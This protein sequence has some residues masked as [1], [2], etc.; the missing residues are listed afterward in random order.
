MAAIQPS[1]TSAGFAVARTSYG[2][3][4]I[5]RFLMPFEALRTHAV[6]RVVNDIKTAIRIHRPRHVSV[7]AHSFGTYVLAKIL[8][9]ESGLRWHRIIFCGSVVREDFPFERFLDQFDGPLLNDIGTGD[10]WPVLAE[11]ATWG[12]SSASSTAYNRPH[13]AARWHIGYRHSDFLNSEFCR[14]YWVPFLRTGEVRPGDAPAQLPPYIRALSWIPVR[15]LVIAALAIGLITCGL[16]FA[17]A[18]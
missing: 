17:P 7:I 5:L 18:R 13:T 6:A 15:W 14:N 16:H 3:F 11:S 9:T 4:S 8:E 2:S 1:L 12:Y 10:A